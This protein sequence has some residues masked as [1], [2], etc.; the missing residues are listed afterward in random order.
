VKAHVD[1]LDP[2]RSEIGR[3]NTQHIDP[4]DEYAAAGETFSAAV[5][6]DSDGPAAV[7]AAAPDERAAADVTA[8][9]AVVLPPNVEHSAAAIVAHTYFELAAIAR[10]RYM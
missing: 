3:A 2:L 7:V 1:E 10:N 4:Y 6:A 9:T 5:H 8:S